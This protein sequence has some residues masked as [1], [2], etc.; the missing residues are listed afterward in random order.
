MLFVF[1][2][3]LAYYDK[4]NKNGIK[5]LVLHESFFITQARPVLTIPVFP[6]SAAHLPEDTA[7]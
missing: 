1:L 6:A 5:L 7:P 4:W 3:H 2:L